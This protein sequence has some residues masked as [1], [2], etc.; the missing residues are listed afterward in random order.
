MD[1]T[2][3][4]LG[5]WGTIGAAIVAAITGALAWINGRQRRAAEDAGYSAEAARSQAEQDIIDKLREEVARLADRVNRLEAEGQR[6]RLRV[7]HLEDEMR[8]HAVPIPPE[9]PAEGAA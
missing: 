3:G 5:M 9:R 8:K 4:N 1:E 7:W 6:L 2:G